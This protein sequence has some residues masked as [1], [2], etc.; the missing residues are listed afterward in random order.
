MDQHDGVVGTPSAR[1]AR[2]PAQIDACALSP[3]GTIVRTLSMPW[4]R[5][6][7]ATSSEVLVGR[8]EVDRVDPFV[9]LEVLERVAQDRLALHR[10]E[11]LR[12]ALGVVHAG[13][14]AAREH[15]H[16]RS[17]RR[18]VDRPHR[19]VAIRPFRS[20]SRPAAVQLRPPIIAHGAREPTRRPFRRPVGRCQDQRM[21]DPR[22]STV[23][24]I[25]RRSADRHPDRVALVF[26]DRRWTYR[27][28]DDAVS[29]RGGAPVHARRQGRPGRRRSARTPTRTCSR[30]SAA[31]APGWCTSRSTTR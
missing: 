18:C 1:A 27:E 22:S 7:S 8:D 15:D 20:G 31:R 5:T 6:R 25:V 26:G 9:A 11:L 23:D 24:D 19:L 14:A 28:L 2:N 13:A 3:T 17:V 10:D 16:D 12:Q 4:A 29:A 30:S 21:A